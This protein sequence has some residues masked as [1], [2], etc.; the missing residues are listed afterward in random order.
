MY[1]RLSALYQEVNK[2]PLSQDMQAGIP[3]LLPEAF[4]ELGTASE[5][6]QVASEEL[7]Q[8]NEELV[9]ARQIIEAERQQYQEL[10]DFAPDGY[11]VTD[12][13][14]IIQEAN[15]AAETL[16]N[17]PKTFLIGKPLTNFVREEDRGMFRTQLTRLRYGD[18]LQEYRVIMQP[19][20]GPAFE[21]AL[22][23]TAVRRPLGETENQLVSLRWLLRDITERK[24]MEA[25]LT[26]ND[27][28]PSQDRP[29]HAYQK[30]EAI[31]L[32]PELIYL[33]HQGLVK[34]STF[35]E[36]SEEVLVGLAGP[37]MPFGSSLTPFQAYQA[38][39]LSE[40]QLV[41]IPLSEIANSPPLAQTLLPRINQRL[42]QA[43]SLLAVSGQRHVRNR[44]H[45]LLL[46]LKQEIGQ[47][48]A[49]E[50]RLSVRLTHEELANTCCTTRVTIT[51]L[52]HD[53]QQQGKISLC[54]KRHLI[55]K[56]KYF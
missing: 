13:A 26:T 33:V 29:L 15:H 1:C 43:E 36:H 41:C 2:L 27:Y 42:K 8:Q 23:V 53:L 7:Q 17:L 30:G 50:T 47:P 52:L 9:A 5:A 54:P 49:Q 24:R 56:N 25:A 51:R 28:D 19:R 21:A 40:V 37:L 11:L 4:K 45:Q 20:H 55:L 12:A 22:T 39:A 31:S 34:L 46:L 3:L 48:G 38:I 18:W 6:L 44:L 10:F 35:S 32:D 14:G 16:L